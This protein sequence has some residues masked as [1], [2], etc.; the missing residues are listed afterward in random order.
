MEKDSGKKRSCTGTFTGNI[1]R[2][3]LWLG[4]VMLLVDRINVGNN[5]VILTMHH[6]VPSDLSMLLIVIDMQTLH[7]KAHNSRC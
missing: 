3:N 6:M 2:R 1:G 5:L 4:F 7:Y